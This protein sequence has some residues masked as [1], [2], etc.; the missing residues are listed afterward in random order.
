M[1]KDHD[2][3]SFESWYMV[4]NGNDKQKA[5]SAIASQMTNEEARTSFRPY[6]DDYMWDNFRVDATGQRTAEDDEVPEGFD[7]PKARRFRKD[8]YTEPCRHGK[9]CWH[10]PGNCKFLHKWDK[11]D[12]DPAE[13]QYVAIKYGWPVEDKDID[14]QALYR[15]KYNPMFMV[16]HS[17][18]HEEMLPELNLIDW[19]DQT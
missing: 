12:L 1:K 4:D 18:T 14:P 13:W 2:D 3:K 16:S 8:R 9:Y 10:Q 6:I 5:W 17:A 7:I 11:S 15:N 19:E